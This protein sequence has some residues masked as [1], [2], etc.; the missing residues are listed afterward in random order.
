MYKVNPHRIARL[1]NISGTLQ[2]A[3]VDSCQQI[4]GYIESEYGEINLSHVMIE[5]SSVILKVKTLLSEGH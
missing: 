5:S 3:T 2:D 1:T 4:R